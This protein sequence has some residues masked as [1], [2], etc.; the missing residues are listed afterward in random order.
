M[1]IRIKALVNSLNYNLFRIKT[2]YKFK[3]GALR[4]KS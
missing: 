1:K 2:L 4:I 3:L